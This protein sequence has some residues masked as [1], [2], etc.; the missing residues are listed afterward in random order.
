M[1]ILIKNGRVLNP[2]TQFD[3][4]IDILVEDK[5]IVK[6]GENLQEQNLYV[7]LFF[8]DIYFC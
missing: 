2:A 7:L 5:C 3:G 6:M 1:K 4:V 8:F